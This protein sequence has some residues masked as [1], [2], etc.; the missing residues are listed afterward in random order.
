MKGIR[1]FA[2]ALR[3]GIN[4]D[5]FPGDNEVCTK[6]VIETDRIWIGSNRSF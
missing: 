3:I 6:R 4:T 2:E 1:A 5:K